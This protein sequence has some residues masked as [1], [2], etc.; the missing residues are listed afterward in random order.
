MP[1]IAAGTIAATIGAAATLGSQG[2]NY[3]S[4]NKTNLKTRQHNEAMYFRQRND[5]L[6]DWN[7]QNEYNLPQN[8]MARLKAA[9]LNPALVYGNGTNTNA[10]SPKPASMQGYNP[11]TPKVDSQ[12]IGQTIG[13][14]YATKTMALQ[15]SILQQNLRNAQK[16][17][18][19]TDAHTLESLAKTG[20]TNVGTKRAEFDLALEDS[21]K[22]YTSSER[23]SKAHQASH[24]VDSLGL[25]TKLKQKELDNKSTQQRLQNEF[26]QASTDEKRKIIEKMEQEIK[27]L[28]LDEKLKQYE[29]DLH[30]AGAQKSDAWYYRLLMQIL[31]GGR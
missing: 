13:N 30:Q 16:A 28:G 21:L 5:N 6:S 19:L 15:E 1:P 27:N 10:D 8:Q 3:A 22:N 9:G 18:S 12:A 29:H 20:A 4:A 23:K 24:I 25:D 2:I 17:E 26:M 31:A 14:F 7:M 11:D